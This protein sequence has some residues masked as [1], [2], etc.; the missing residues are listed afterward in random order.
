M[1]SC[2]HYLMITL[3]I[4]Q[5]EGDDGSYQSLIDAQ[6]ASEQLYRNGSL[7]FTISHSFPQRKTND[8]KIKGNLA[9]R[10]DAAFWS[11]RV[12]Y[13]HRTYSEYPESPASIDD[14]EMQYALRRDGLLYLYSSSN[15]TLTIRRYSGASSGGTIF[16][17]IDVIPREQWAGVIPTLPAAGR[18]WKEMI[19]PSSPVARSGSTF[20]LD[21]NQA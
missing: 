7:T 9:W 5:S 14:A 4:T 15:K 17:L 16:N 19:G 21:P 11:F 18:T 12:C 6:I 8:V 2:G 3:L 1:L 20:S 10:P 13:P